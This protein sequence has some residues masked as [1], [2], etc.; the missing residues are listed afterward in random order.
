[1]NQASF[2]SETYTY[3]F[4]VPS[5]IY[6]ADVVYTFYD[7]GP[8]PDVNTTVAEI[9]QGYLTR[10]AET[11]QP[12]DP[13]LPFFSPARPGLTVQNLESDF[14]D[15]TLDERGIKQLSERCRF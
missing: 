10:F 12:N 13:T 15:P 1:M 3:K 5:A 11:G 9:M 8:V 7:F 14:M 6:G 4:S 2:V